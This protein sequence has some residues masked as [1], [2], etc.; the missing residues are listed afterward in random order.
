[1]KKNKTNKNQMWVVLLIYIFAGFALAPFVKNLFDLIKPGDN[2]Y[3]FRFVIMYAIPL[4]ISVFLHTIIHE[5]GHLVFG[6]LSGY[7]CVSF[8]IFSFMWCGQDGKIVLKRVRIPGTAGQ[9]LMSPPEMRDGKIPFKLYNLGGSI[10]NVVFSLVAAGLTLLLPEGIFAD[11]LFIFSVIG[12][13]LALINA[14]PLTVSDLNNDGK[15][16]LSLGKSK[17][18]LRAFYIVL[19][20]N[21][22]TTKGFM[23]K[24]MP[25]ELFI[26]P[27]E[28]GLK[29]PMSAQLVILVLGR[30][31]E[32]GN[33]E[34]AA[35]IMDWFMETDNA[36]PKINIKVLKL[37]RLY[38]E[39]VCKRR[40]EYIDALYSKKQQ[41]FIKAMGGISP[42]VIHAVYAYTLLITGDRNDAEKLKERFLKKSAKYPYKGDIIRALDMMRYADIISGGPY[43]AKEN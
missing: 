4:L 15:N 43:S 27:S 29:N 25:D 22:Y 31:M 2:G 9:C 13:A 11:I 38:C 34:N 28:Q 6:L 3:A 8:R 37:D 23:Y 7:K 40:P 35:E 16:A 20:I 10:M 14:I 24:D 21:E 5:S 1:M 19:K 33:Y 41:M 42:A 36:L 39:I 26:L 32:N 12:I 17:E 18:A 30:I